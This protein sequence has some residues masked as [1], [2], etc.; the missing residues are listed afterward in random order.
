MALPARNSQWS[1]TVLRLLD[2]LVE[3]TAEKG[4][5][6]LQDP[7]TGRYVNIN[8]AALPAIAGLIPVEALGRIEAAL[9]I[10]A[11]AQQRSAPSDTP[12]Q[13]NGPAG[14]DGEQLCGRRVER[15]PSEEGGQRR[16]GRLPETSGCHPSVE[17]PGARRMGRPSGNQRAE[18]LLERRRLERDFRVHGHAFSEHGQGWPVREGVAREEGMGKNRGRDP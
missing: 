13:G 15:D 1:K 18:D 4:K 9:K 16:Q 6:R 11:Q 10:T 7:N 14:V 2:E 17:R 8:A 5:L 3:K 12:E